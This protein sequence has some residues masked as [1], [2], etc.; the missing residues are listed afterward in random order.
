MLFIVVTLIKKQ[1]KERMQVG[2]ANKQEKQ[3]KE[4]KRKRGLNIYYISL[5]LENA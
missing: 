5:A 3:K 1:K 4:T 2:R